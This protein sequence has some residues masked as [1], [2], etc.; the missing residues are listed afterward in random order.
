M[1]SWSSATESGS[2]SC[3]ANCLSRSSGRTR[4]SSPS[5]PASVD[6]S[7]DAVNN[8]GAKGDAHGR[9]SDDDAGHRP[10]PAGRPGGAGRERAASAGTRTRRGA[11][12]CRRRRGQPA[13]HPPAQG[14]IPAAAGRAQHPGTGGGGRGRRARC[15][16]R[17]CGARPAGL[18]AA[19]GRG[20]CRICGG[21]LGPMPAGARR[22]HDGGG[23]RAARDGVHRLDQPVRARLCDRGRHRAGPWRHQRHRHHRDRAVR[24][25]WRPLHCHCRLCG[26]M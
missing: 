9:T 22:D 13:R 3:L 11:D 4:G 14:R 26:E 21:A 24:A 5:I 2:R 23:S 10:G 12:P 19:R 1:R 18:R 25:V 16:R 17:R 15:G 20:L 6:R 8:G 7:R